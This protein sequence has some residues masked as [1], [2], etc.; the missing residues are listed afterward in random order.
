MGHNSKEA[1]YER[2]RELS[3][4]NRTSIKESK[5]RAIGSLIDYKRSADGIAY[6]IIKENHK[7]YIKKAGIK[8]TPDASDFAYIGGMQN[9]TNYQYNTLA[10]ADKNRNMLLHTINEAVSLDFRKNKVNESTADTEIDDAEAKLD[11]L[12]AATAAEKTPDEEM[13]AGLEAEPEGGEEIP[14]DGG[15]ELPADGGEEI[16]TDGGEELPDMGGEELPADDGGE[17]LPADDGGESVGPDADELAEDDPLKEIEKSLGKIT[18]KIRKAEIE[19]NQ[20][21]AFVNTFLSAFK[22]KFADVEIEDR[23]EMANKILKVVPPEDVE[24]LGADIEKDEESMDEGGCNECS[25]FAQY[26]ESMGYDSAESL[27]ECGEEEVTNLVSGFANANADGENDGDHENVALVIKLVNPEILNKLKDE[28]GH[29]EYA[30]KLTPYVDQMNEATEENLDELFS[31][32]KNMFKSYGNSA[33]QGV[34]KGANALGGAVKQGA[35]AVKGAAQQTAN[36]IGGAV[37][38]GADAVKGAAQ[39]TGQTVKQTAQNIGNDIKQ[40][41]HAGEQGAAMKK[42]NKIAQEFKD[43]VEQMNNHAAKAGE[44]PVPMEQVLNILTQQLTDEVPSHIAN[45]PSATNAWKQGKTRNLNKLAVSEDN[46]PAAVEVQPPVEDTSEP[47]NDTE[48]I[49]D[50]AP[51]AD[52]L[53]IGTPSS[54]TT[55]TVESGKVDVTLNETEQKLRKY[56]RNRLEEM[57]GLKK[58]S[59][60]EDKKSDKLKKLDEMIATKYKA[61]LSKIKKK[62]N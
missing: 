60:N 21:K 8:D 45:N 33:A 62:I 39:Q 25:E 44:E 31:G 57:T 42:L 22:D 1:F 2:L 11:D 26:A 19:P 53:G 35:D 54:T 15:E 38:Q 14:T 5:N 47:V 37:K 49:S 16:P 30:E 4:V 3:D 27:M 58:P 23:K 61:H 24:G 28:Y 9:I 10:E 6:G 46:D 55:V 32:L 59:L 50:I 18:N 43:K 17:E 56:I 36:T 41:Y 12:D 40:K 51:V 20:V 13:A 48:P 34:K 29:G 7:Y 52:N